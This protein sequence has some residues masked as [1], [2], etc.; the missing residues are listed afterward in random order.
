MAILNPDMFNPVQLWA[1]LGGGKALRFIMKN[2]YEPIWKT[3]NKF[4]V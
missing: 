4:F 3:L 1:R 2:F